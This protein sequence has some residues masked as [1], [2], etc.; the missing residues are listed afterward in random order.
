MSFQ[1]NSIEFD[2]REYAY[3]NFGG[4]RSG[5]YV[6][7][8]CPFHPEV[9]PSCCVYADSYHC[10]GAGCGAHGSAVDFIHKTTGL[11]IKEVLN[12]YH[13]ISKSV[14]PKR[15]DTKTNYPSEWRIGIYHQ[16]LLQRPEKLNY[17]YKRHFD[18]FSIGQA[19]LGYMA[20]P[21]G[22]TKFSQPRF[23]IPV[24]DRTGKLITARYRIDPK[25]DDHT[26]PKYLAHPKAP[27]ALYNAH[28]LDK[29]ED[30]LIVGSEFDAAFLYFRFGIYA[31]AP[32]GENNFKPDWAY[33]FRNHNVLIWLDYDYAGVNAAIKTYNLIKPYSK[34]QI[35][36][37][38]SSFRNKDDICDFVTERSVFGVIQELDKYNVK[39]Y[40]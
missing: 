5:N 31:V 26:E 6:K 38:E 13:G 35:Y 7:I 36:T 27:V 23:V 29:Y 20:R 14:L 34:A 24:F 10:F 11:S 32:P 2:L 4:E 21:I 15:S 39:A 40:S 3:D 18:S 25:Y 9:T 33:D 8:P 16:S 1:R 28:L 19:R 17:L 30:I 22:F 37:W 12:G